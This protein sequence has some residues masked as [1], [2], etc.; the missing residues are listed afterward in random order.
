MIGGLLQIPANFCYAELASAFPEDGGQYVYFREAGSR[1]LA[2]LCGWISFWATD[3]PSISIMA[4]AIANYLGF[5]LP[6]HG[7][8]LKLVAVALVIVFMIIHIRSVEGGG[9]FQTI[10]TALKILPFALII[11]IGLFNINSNLFLS[12]KPLE[13]AAT[14]FAALLAGISATTWS[15]DGMGAA[16]YMSGEIKD[17]R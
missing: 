12:S 14:G 7:L 13:G 9:K 17:S 16:C 1:P 3:P 2:F 5:F 8:I 6:V 4:L 11:G 15:Y 10:I